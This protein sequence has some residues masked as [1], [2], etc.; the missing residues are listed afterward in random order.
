MRLQEFERGR[1]EAA[2]T[3]GALGGLRRLFPRHR[4]STASA[5]CTCRRS[6]RPTPDRPLIVAEGFPR[7]W[8]RATS[9]ERLFRDNPVLR[10]RRSEVEPVYWDEIATLRPLSER[11]RGVH[12][13]SSARPSSARRRHPHLRPERARAAS[14]ASASGRACRRLEPATLNEFQWVC[15]LAHLRY[16]ALLA[17]DARPPADA[18]GPRDRGAGLGGARQ[19]Q[20][21][22]RRDPRHL[23]AHGRTRTCGG[24]TSSS[25][26]STG[27]PPRCAASAAG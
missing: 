24:S 9:T 2:T 5:T 17:A 20:R 22:D 14:A 19:E 4:R 10:Q 21:H 7:S 8:S 18:L 11:E 3:G 27:S 15:Q 26:S 12:R 23:H 6:A 13:R 1:A 16:C 25:G